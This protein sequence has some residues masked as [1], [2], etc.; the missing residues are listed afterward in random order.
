MPGE[1]TPPDTA[2]AATET[3][4]ANN[5]YATNRQQDQNRGNNHRNNNNNNRN[6]N[7]KNNRTLVDKEDKNYKGETPEVGGILALCTEKLTKKL[8]FDTFR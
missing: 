3:A 2:V 5:S 4:T 1:T 8:T 7:R 6:N